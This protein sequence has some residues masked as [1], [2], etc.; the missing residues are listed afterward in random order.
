[1]TNL[2][3]DGPPSS[4]TFD[5]DTVVLYHDSGVAHP[6]CIPK[7]ENFGVQRQPAEARNT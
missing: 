1:V 6:R 3:F 7:I 2:L 4:L 5:S